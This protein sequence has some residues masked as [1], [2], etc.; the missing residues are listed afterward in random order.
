MASKNDESRCGSFFPDKRRRDY[1][2]TMKCV[3]QEVDLRDRI[4]SVDQRITR[5]DRILPSRSSFRGMH[6]RETG[7]KDSWSPKRVR[8][9]FYGLLWLVT[10]SLLPLACAQT[11]TVAPPPSPTV[12]AT[13]SAA[14]PTRNPTTPRPTTT[15]PVA[16]HSQWRQHSQW[17]H[18]SQ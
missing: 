8:L 1:Y 15:P 9:L 5:D 7:N 11:T 18:H 3:C 13:P 4:A 16:H 2:S 6:E 17:R 10:V 12:G 14:A